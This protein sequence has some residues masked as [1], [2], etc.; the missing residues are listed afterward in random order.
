M[1]V[2]SI[3]PHSTQPEDMLRGGI[4]VLN[5]KGDAATLSFGFQFGDEKF[6]LTVG[7]LFAGVGDLVFAFSEDD[8]IQ[9]EEGPPQ[10]FMYEIGT[11]R[12][13]SRDTDSAVF[14]I[15]DKWEV[16][17]NKLPDGAGLRGPLI[18]PKPEQSPAGVAVGTELVGYA[19]FTRG[20]AGKVATSAAASGQFILDGD[21]GMVSLGSVPR[22]IASAGDC[23]T[24]FVEHATGTPVYFHHVRCDTQSYGV[25]FA[26]IMTRHIQ[27]G[28]T[29]VEA[30]E[31]AQLLVPPS[32]TGV[33]GDYDFAHFNTKIVDPP[34][35]T[36][37]RLNVGVIV[38][39]IG[40]K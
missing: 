22:E 21:I 36:Y 31:C 26:K 14:E 1:K 24:L 4:F 17:Y 18:L 10:Y 39:K 3:E 37:D 38:K 16:D 23:G 6:G 11:V 15:N 29:E 30:Q 5:S 2:V 33:R 40:Q 25:P 28:G 27:F 13:I 19:A 35:E 7:H 34:E 20:A 8:P 9:V 32:Q 12:S